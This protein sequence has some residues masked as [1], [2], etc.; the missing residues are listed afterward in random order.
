MEKFE[1]FKK[2]V[3]DSLLLWDDKTSELTGLAEKYSG[4]LEEQ[5]R[6]FMKLKLVV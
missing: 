5:K 2:D 6:L 4:A 1:E 3:M